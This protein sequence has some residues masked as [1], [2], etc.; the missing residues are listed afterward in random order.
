MT[1][2][3]PQPL[4]KQLH[5]YAQQNQG[6]IHKALLQ[7]CIDKSGLSLA[8]LL[9]T[10]QPVAALFSIAPVS[11]F[12]VGAVAY[13]NRTGNAYLG[14]NLEFSHQALSLVVHAEQSAINTAWLNGETEISHLSISAAPCGYC[15][16]FINELNHAEHIGISF[17]GK[18][19]NITELLPQAFGP[20]DL[21]NPSKLLQQNH[22]QTEVSHSDV[23]VELAL[24]FN[25]SYAPY[26]GNKSAVE[27]I[28][29]DG[30]C[31]YGRYAENAAYSPSLSPLQSALSQVALSGVSLAELNVA[32][33]TLVQTKGKDNQTDVTRAVLASYPNKVQLTTV[34]I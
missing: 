5:D 29:A 10:L 13:S 19:T 12:Y 9:E 7:S 21:N 18:Q 32:K 4:S 14:A 1:T 33:V 27:I 17:S 22:E 11:N 23:S 6:V 20:E 2:T 34:Y 26:S 25:Q 31:F 3:L 16:Q 30:H 24:H 28:T 8:Q 15:R